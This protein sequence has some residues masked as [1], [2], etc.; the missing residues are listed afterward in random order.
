MRIHRSCGQVRRAFRGTTGK[1]EGLL[2]PANFWIMKREPLMPKQNRIRRE[3][4]HEEVYGLLMTS[5]LH[6]ERDIMLDC[7]ISIGRP[8]SIRGGNRTGHWDSINP[9]VRNIFS[10]NNANICDTAVNQG[11][12]DSK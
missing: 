3:F 5:Y 10:I 6:L 4:S 11:G 8:I 12:L 1:G 7:P 2:F 9:M